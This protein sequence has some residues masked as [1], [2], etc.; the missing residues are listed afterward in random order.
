MKTARTD[1]GRQQ[2]GIALIIVM[3]SIFVLTMLAGGFAY[4]MKVET[5]LARN[6]NSETELEWLGRSGV[7]Y[8]RWVLANSLKNP[9]QPY[10]S[11]DQPWATGTGFLGPTNAPIAEVQNPVT[12]GGGKFTWK[13]VDMERKVNINVAPEPVLKQALIQMGVDASSETV[14]TGSI[15]DWIDPDNNAHLEGAE[16]EYYQ[17][18]EPSYEAKNGPIDDMSELLLI[19]GVTPEV[20]WGGVA[21]NHPQGALQPRGGRFGMQNTAP[22]FSGGLVDL[23]TPVSSGRINL[24]TASADVIQLVVP[25]G[26][27]M[28]AEAIVGGRSG[29][30]DPSG[31]LGPYRSVSD[32]Q[33]V[34]DIPRGGPILQALTQYC[35]TR[36]TT[37][38]VTV[39]AEINGYHR[40]FVAI[41]YRAN[42]HDV[43]VVNFYWK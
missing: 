34:P 10:D 15:L 43:Q 38:E 27:R 6:A 24:N 20:F 22:V 26:D 29:E 21:T 41:L 11:L 35:D 9:Q 37:F 30:A 25:G 36:S 7:E 17:G 5:R 42:D 16:T 13:I 19:K 39:D 12:L 14:I 33:R 31:L 18:L 3:I 1:R 28:A 40:H 4:S 8:A 2:L 23:F 32:V